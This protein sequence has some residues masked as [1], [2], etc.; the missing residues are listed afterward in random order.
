MNVLVLLGGDSTERE[1]SLRSGAAIGAALR[2][3]QHVVTTYD[4]KNGFDGLKKAIEN[5]DVVLPILHGDNGEDGVIQEQLEQLGKPYLGATS[6]VSR[7]TINKPETH[8]ILEE[9]GVT[10]AQFE[11]VDER[12]YAASNLSK[13]PHVLKTTE[14]G[15]SVDILVARNISEATTQRAKELLQK[16]KTMLLEVLIEG[17]EVTVPILGNSALPAIVIIPPEDEE[18]DYENKYNGKTQEICPIPEDLVAAE[19]Q[20]EAQELAEKTHKILGVR[21]LSRTDMI[22]KDNGELVVLEINTIPGLTDQSLFPKSA[23]ESGLS[24]KQLVEEF[25]QMASER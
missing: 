12:S 13:K 24:M 2:E 23:Q 10:M 8:K 18:F 22:L 16:H 14:G 6:S 4:P 3:T 19:K 20:K 7:I 5:V 17:L 15:S 11:I 1:V 9:H 25:V 21:H